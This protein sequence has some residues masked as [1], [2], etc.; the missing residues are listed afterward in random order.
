MKK[1][2]SLFLIFGI[3]GC[4]PSVQ[5]KERIA[6]VTCSIIKETLDFQSSERVEKI[7]EAR[8]KIKLPPYLDGDEEILRSIEFNT[9]E[10]LVKNDETYYEKTNQI[11]ESFE[12]IAKEQREARAIARELRE[13]RAAQLEMEK[14]GWSYYILE[15]ELYSQ[16]KYANEMVTILKRSGFPAFFEINSDTKLYTVY[17][18][19]ISKE[20]LNDNIDEIQELTQSNS[21]TILRWEP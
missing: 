16:E 2:L 1:I 17:A 10:L 13:A 14:S 21:T 9:C 11:E 18:G 8:E 19:P 15:V 4:S 7:N 12:A 20:F 6:S 5:E 3:V